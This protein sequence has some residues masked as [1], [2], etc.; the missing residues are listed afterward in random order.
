MN[1][2]CVEKVGDFSSPKCPDRLWKPNGSPILW[3]PGF[4]AG[5]LRPRRDFQHWLP[6]KLRLSAVIP[7]LPLYAFTWTEKTYAL[8][9]AV[10][11]LWSYASTPSIRL[12]V[13]R[14]NLRAY[15][16]D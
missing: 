10:W 14:D 11:N 12:N 13:G 16:R 9:A 1:I 8:N 3:I 6:L 15:C 7:L 2:L 4:S 5:E